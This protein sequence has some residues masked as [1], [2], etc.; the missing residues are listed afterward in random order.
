MK[1]SYEKIESSEF[2][3]VFFDHILIEDVKKY[4]HDTEFLPVH[5]PPVLFLQMSI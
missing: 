5:L 1:S 4:F 3:P 2:P